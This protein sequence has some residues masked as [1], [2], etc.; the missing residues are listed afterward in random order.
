VWLAVA[1]TA[2]ASRVAAA[3]AG[4]DHAMG[5]GGHDSAF[6]AMQS[7][8]QV[9]MGVDQ[10][11][12]VHHFEDLPDGGRISLE[13]DSTDSA[14]VAAIRNHLQDITRAFAAGDFGAPGFVHDG[15]VPGTGTMAA[16][17]DRIVYQFVP[18]PVGG[19]V[20]IRTT[21]PG[22]LRAVH[23]FLAFQRREHR[24]ADPHQAPAP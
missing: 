3:Q 4:H 19:A 20:R 8:G 16:R 13:R 18:L 7:R 23:E 1:L 22:A 15:E 24:T 2:G 5:H 10:Y 9:A 6:A 21:D 12:S 17:R 14:G 11:T